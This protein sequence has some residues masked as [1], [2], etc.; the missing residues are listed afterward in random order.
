MNYIM[1]YIIIDLNVMISNHDGVSYCKQK[2]DQ[3]NH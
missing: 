1:F 3:E 2:F